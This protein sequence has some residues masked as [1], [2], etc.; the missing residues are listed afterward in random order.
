M[1]LIVHWKVPLPFKQ[2]C[3]GGC[4]IKSRSDICGDQSCIIIQSKRNLGQVNEQTDSYEVLLVEKTIQNTLTSMNQSSL[5]QN[6]E[7]SSTL[8]N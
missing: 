7:L 1:I 4:K 5:L 3:L 6:I 2:L 8:E